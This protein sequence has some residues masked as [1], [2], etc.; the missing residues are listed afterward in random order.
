MVALGLHE[1]AGGSLS[2]V[3]S[4]RGK[5]PPWRSSIAVH[6]RALADDP[7]GAASALHDDV[8]LADGAGW[9]PLPVV[10]LEVPANRWLDAGKLLARFIDRWGD[11]VVTVIVGDVLDDDGPSQTVVHEALSRC[12]SVL[13]GL[14]S[15]ALLLA[16]PLGKFDGGHPLDVWI[17][18][19]WRER[20][21]R[22][23]IMQWQ[24]AR[25]AAEAGANGVAIDVVGDPISSLDHLEASTSARR[26]PDGSHRGGAAW[27]D[28]REASVYA[29][30]K[31]NAQ[32]PRPIVGVTASIGSRTYPRGWLANLSYDLHQAPNV[33]WLLWRHAVDFEAKDGPDAHAADDFAEGLLRWT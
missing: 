9:R 18:P 2:A 4:R 24:L 12:R 3:L 10:T 13:T 14:G 6:R 30:R 5:A 20:P 28:L 8:A 25:I 11:G 15:Q 17:E 31:A 29:W 1:T 33:E 7:A 26:L 21:S 19:R 16:P 27:R 32:S 22:R 23:E